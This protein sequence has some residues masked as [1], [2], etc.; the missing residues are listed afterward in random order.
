MEVPMSVQR[1]FPIVPYLAC[2]AIAACAE[3]RGPDDLDSG[4]AREVRGG[5]VHTERIARALDLAAIVDT[6]S[7][8]S[9]LGTIRADDLDERRRVTTTDASS[10]ALIHVQLGQRVD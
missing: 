1:T 6:P 2:L 5:R 9:V 10:T 8:R 7:L 3:A 4:F